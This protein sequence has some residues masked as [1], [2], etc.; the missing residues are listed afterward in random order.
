[1]NIEDSLN[2]YLLQ[3]FTSDPT[4]LVL[5][6]KVKFFLGRENKG[7]VND[8]VNASTRAVVRVLA[9]DD[10]IIPNW[11]HY[12]RVIARPIQAVHGQVPVSGIVYK[13]DSRFYLVDGYH[14]LK[15][16]REEDFSKQGIYIVLS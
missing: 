9:I 11:D 16:A 10:I 15:W 14:R 2:A 8:R 7:I 3:G 12:E 13:R 6:D 4:T 5:L 1:M